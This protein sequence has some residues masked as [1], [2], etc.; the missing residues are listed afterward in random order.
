MPR[1]SSW[2]SGWRVGQQHVGD[3][4]AIERRGDAGL[5]RD[6][7]RVGRLLLVEAHGAQAQAPADDR[8]LAGLLGQHGQDRVGAADELLAS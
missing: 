8:G 1:T 7:Q 5:Q 4:A 3:R 6:P 2:T